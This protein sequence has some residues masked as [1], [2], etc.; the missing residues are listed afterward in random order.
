MALNGMFLSE[1]DAS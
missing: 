1:P